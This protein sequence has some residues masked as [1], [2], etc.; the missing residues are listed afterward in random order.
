M[1]TV[2]PI[3]TRFQ[4]NVEIDDG[5]LILD[6]IH[7]CTLVEI[8]SKI[9]DLYFVKQFLDKDY[10]TNSISYTGIDHS[11]HVLYILVKYFN[12]NITHISTLNDVTL[13]QIMTKIKAQKK[14]CW[15]VVKGNIDWGKSHG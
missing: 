4:G 13:C 5:T 11:V 9:M 1:T 14:Y 8:S 3:S 7:Y 15:M 6:E 10:I 2:D 12:F